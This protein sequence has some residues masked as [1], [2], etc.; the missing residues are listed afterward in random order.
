MKK[1]HVTL[2]LVAALSISCGGGGG[3]IS[4]SEVVLKFEELGNEYVNYK[5]N[6]NIETNV[7]GQTRSWLSESKAA[8]KVIAI[9]EDGSIMRALKYDDFSMGEISGTGTLIPNPT[10][11]DYIGEK[12]Q[13]T[14]GK[15][16]Q[17]LDWNGLDGISGLTIE[18]NSYRDFMVQ[19]LAEIFQPMPDYAVSVGGKW[20]RI[21]ETVIQVG[22]GDLKNKVQI[23][24]ELVGFGKKSGR[25]CA[26]IKT[27]YTVTG[28]A[29]GRR[30]GKFWLSIVGGGD[31]EIWFD[32]TNGVLVEYSKKVTLTRDYSYERAGE[33]DVKTETFTIDREFKVKLEA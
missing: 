21:L 8:V 33:E 7:G 12:L 20:Q 3:G 1:L 19:Q 18:G 30:R 22:G 14:I 32:Y 16:G 25:D 4:P 2:A 13:L 26:R 11:D 9:N 28:S 23:D 17:I 27:E 24:Y 31:G 10:A 29:A 6:T 15:E 5:V